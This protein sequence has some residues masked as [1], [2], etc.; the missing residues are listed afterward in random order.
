VLLAAG[1]IDDSA[2]NLNRS[3]SG[4][5]TRLPFFACFFFFSLLEL[6]LLLPLPAE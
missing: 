2:S 5:S 3:S 1:S 6:L 4:I